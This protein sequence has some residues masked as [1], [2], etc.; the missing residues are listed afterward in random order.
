[1]GL[2]RRLKLTFTQEII[3]DDGC[4]VKEKPAISAQIVE[5]ERLFQETFLMKQFLQRRYLICCLRA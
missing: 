3:T 4:F 2:K 5:P 1:M